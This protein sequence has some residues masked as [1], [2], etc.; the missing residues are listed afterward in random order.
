[1]EVSQEK[2]PGNVEVLALEV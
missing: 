1:M 2:W